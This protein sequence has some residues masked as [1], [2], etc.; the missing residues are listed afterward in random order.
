MKFAVTE[1]AKYFSNEVRVH[2]RKKQNALKKYKTPS[3]HKETAAKSWKKNLC[4][5]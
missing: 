1:T 5:Y 3:P 2:V 4:Y